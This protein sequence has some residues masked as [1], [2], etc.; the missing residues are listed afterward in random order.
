MSK[1]VGIGEHVITSNVNDTL[2]AFALSTCIGLT[3]Y[4]PLKRVLGMA[5]IALPCSSKSKNKALLGYYADTAVPFM[6]D[7]MCYRYGC[8]IDE[9]KFCL[10]G[11]AKSPNGRDFFKI[12]EQNIK[13]VKAILSS[14]KVAYDA[15]ETGGVR[16]RTVKVDAATG[17]A[18]IRYH[19]III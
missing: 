19:S 7:K 11:G 2:T 12:G 13:A 6:I 10:Y 5:H 1:V 8:N 14:L 18:K 3:L 16:S 4:S 17:R 15:K 9:I